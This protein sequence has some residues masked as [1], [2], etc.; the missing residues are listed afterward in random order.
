MTHFDVFKSHSNESVKLEN[1]M[2]LLKYIVSNNSYSK[3]QIIKKNKNCYT[4][5]LQS[6]SMFDDS[7]KVIKTANNVFLSHLETVSSH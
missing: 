3:M 4:Y 2:R 6:S 1:G 5:I 7:D